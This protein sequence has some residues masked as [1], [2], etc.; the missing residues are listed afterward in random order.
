MRDPDPN[1][2]DGGKVLGV[3]IEVMN[4]A[5]FIRPYYVLLN[6][7]Y[8]DSRGLR[9][10]RHTVPPCI[11]LSGLAARYLPPPAKADDGEQ[12]RSAKKQDLARFVRTLRREI[13]RYH[14][15]IAVI[16]DLRKAVGL[17]AKKKKGRKSLDES[18]LLDISAADPEA[19]QVKVE[20]RDG[21]TG[22]L[23]IGDDGEVV[24]LL[25]FEGKSRD[26]DATRELL[27]E[28]TTRLED[29]AKKMGAV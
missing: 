13:V 12:Q 10:H 1:A 27:G 8:G 9:V 3:R 21:R 25:V 24:K 2:V 28:G 18:P 20:W 17:D 6:R 14:N 19:K 4:R 7:P 11:P 26:R 23:I 16:A 5:K 15:R 29:L 22:R